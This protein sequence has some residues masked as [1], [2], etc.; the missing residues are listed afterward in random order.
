MVHSDGNLFSILVFFLWIPVALWG[1]RRWPP[2]KAAA[3]LFLL[4]LM[5]LPELVYFDLPGLPFF[6]KE[7][8][9]IFWLLI[10]VLLFHRERLTTVQLSRWTKLSM[11]LL[12]GGS[13]VT[14]FLNSD[15]ISEGSTSLPGHQPY[16][17]VNALITGTLDWLLPFALAAA[18]FRDAKDLRL[19]FRFLVGATLVYSI[20]QLIEIRLSPQLHAWV[21]G[22]FQHSF[23]Q[24]M[25]GEG[26]RPIV[27]MAHA[28]AVAMFTMVGVLAAATLY[29][30]KTKVLGVSALW[31]MAFLWV[32]ALLNKSVAA[33][34]YTLAAV[35]LILFFTPK[36][37]FRVAMLLAVT[38]LLYPALRARS[39][40]PVED[41]VGV[42]DAQFG[43]ERA[44]SLTTRFEN[45]DQLLER[46][47]ERLFFG[48]GTYGR[49]NIYEHWSGK[50]KSISDGD[51]II[52]MG[53]WGLVGFLA[54]YLLLLLPIFVA[55]RRIRYL[56]RLSDRRFL[57]ALALIIGF[58]AFDMLP[59]GNYHYLPF[60]FSGAL[61]GCSTGMLRHAAAQARLKR[62]QATAHQLDREI[63][64]RQREASRGGTGHRF[65]G[66]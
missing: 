14:V 36:T 47:R 3:L 51:W 9:A 66:Q 28:L 33:F 37:Q 48:W 18:M 56:R 61:F 40:I 64:V 11:L 1:A 46:A 27:F 65:G 62:R 60:V 58:S 59:N 6:N 41:I 26:F 24:M 20:F 13:V 30:T 38:V 54:K 19:L 35:P 8:I 34:L 55:A 17:A 10:G 50:Q 12:L 52:T 22:F 57:S 25:R 32:I 63:E 7:R 15:S 5:F 29:K 16:D 23:A 44:A 21:Y 39:L 31:V 53:N 45:E 43:E 4:P 2:A 42:V 49:A